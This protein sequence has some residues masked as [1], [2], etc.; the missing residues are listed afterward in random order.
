M[1]LQLVVRR[2]ADME[3]ALAFYVGVLGLEKAHEIRV[4]GGKHIVYAAPASRAWA[5][6]L[7]QDSGPAPLVDPGEH[8]SLECDALEADLERIR[9]RGGAVEG[10]KALPGGARFAFVTDPDGHRIRLGEKTGFLSQGL[11]PRL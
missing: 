10:P 6:Q 7:V 11:G 1:N 2:T 5:F 9:A 8:V 4:P 3:K